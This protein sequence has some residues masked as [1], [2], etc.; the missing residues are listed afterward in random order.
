MTLALTVLNQV[1]VMLVL[2]LIGMLC[3][4]IKLINDDGKQQ[5]TAILL[6]VVNPLVV[7]NAYQTPFEPRLAKNLV[8]AF[9]LGIVS[10]LIAM[11]VAYLLIRTKGNEVRAP[12]ERFAVIYTNCGFMALPLVNA[13]FG[14]EGVFYASAYMTVF[15]IFSWTHGYITMSG[16]RDK[17]AI[18]KAFVSPVVISVIIGILMFFLQ[19]QLPQVLADSVSFMAS[20]NTPLAMLVT[21]VSLAQIP[22]LTA[23]RSLRCYYIVF[24]M[25]LLVPIIAASIYLFLPFERDLILVNLIATAC[26]CAVTTLLFATKFQRDIPHATKLLTLSN[27]VCI[28]TIPLII[29]FFQFFSQFIAF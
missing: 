14:S 22:I 27:I 23:F 18:L 28:A 1:L 3:F 11:A 10:H 19:I 21:G 7:I 12:L 17:S 16:K 26:P 29:F 6:Y 20:L 25:N 5:L 9:L 15:N 4:K 2:M 8:I 13:L 24:L